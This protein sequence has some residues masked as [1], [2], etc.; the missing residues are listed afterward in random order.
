MCD[1]SEGFLHFVKLGNA[2][3]LNLT[4]LDKMEEAF[5]KVTHHEYLGI[6]VHEQYYYSDYYQ[7]QPDYAEK[8][9]KMCEILRASGYDYML[10]EEL[11]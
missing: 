3:C 6:C 9:Y 7:Y 11:I 2:P 1:L 5:G 4:E 10:G 8:I